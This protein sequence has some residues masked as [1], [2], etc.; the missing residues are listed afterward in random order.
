M[1][2]VA[3]IVAIILHLFLTRSRAGLNLR[4]VG[5]NPATADAAGINVTKY[6]YIAIIVGSGITGLGGVLYVLDYGN[7]TW[8]TASGDAIEALAYFSLSLFS[9]IRYITLPFYLFPHMRGFLIFPN[10]FLCNFSKIRYPAHF[11][12]IF[13]FTA[14]F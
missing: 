2:D 6:K 13:Q 14:D 5:E 3:I 11:H 12:R 1:V 4:A 8:A 7:G 10:T 9:S